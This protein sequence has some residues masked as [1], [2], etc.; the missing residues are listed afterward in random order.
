MMEEKLKIEKMK[1][2]LDDEIVDDNFL[3]ALKESAS[4]IYNNM[5][6]I[7]DNDDEGEE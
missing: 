4:A 5:E 1:V 6:I 7:N 2:G 3:E